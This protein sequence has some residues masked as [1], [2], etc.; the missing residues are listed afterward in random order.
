M[1]F[2]ILFPYIRAKIC[3]ID[4][5]Y[6]LPGW[7]MIEMHICRKSSEEFCSLEKIFNHPRHYRKKNKTN[8]ISLT[9]TAAPV[10]KY[11]GILLKI[12]SSK[13]CDLP[14][15]WVNLP[16]KNLE[17]YSKQILLHSKVKKDGWNLW[18]QQRDKIEFCSSVIWLP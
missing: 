16:K 14:T 2:Y 18:L 8:E 15:D 13:T 10:V 12:S 6:S 9:L 7:V 11:S 1:G 5:V 3:M 17:P 4:C